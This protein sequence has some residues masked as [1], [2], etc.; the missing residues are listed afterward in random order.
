MSPRSLP[1][2]LLVCLASA[3]TA[4]GGSVFSSGDQDSGTHDASAVDGPA[5]DAGGSDGGI[6]EGGDE[7]KPLNPDCPAAVPAAGAACTHENVQCEYGDAWWSVSCDTV[8][9]CQSGVW[10]SFKPSFEPCS[11]QPPATNPT[12][13]PATF[14]DVPQGVCSDRGLSCVYP[15]GECSCQV[16]LGGPVLIDGGVADWGC[17]PETG[18]PFP[19]PLLGVACNSPGQTCTYEAC[20]YGETC[21]NGT[22]QAQEEGCAGAQG[23]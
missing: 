20:S 4:C 14:A 5:G 9:Q 18:C 17:V 10:Q 23:Q 16:P 1:C 7:T 19:R 6:S 15:Q 12:P 21:Q 11:S 22:W 8:M 13:C 3:S 2:V